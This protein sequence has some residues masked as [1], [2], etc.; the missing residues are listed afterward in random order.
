MYYVITC[1]AIPLKVVD[2]E[3]YAELT[4]RY[5]DI[6]IVQ[7]GSE[8]TCNK[9]IEDLNFESQEIEIDEYYNKD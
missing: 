5:E 4:A 9:Y 7:T 6:S 2:E 3:T 8:K 1:N